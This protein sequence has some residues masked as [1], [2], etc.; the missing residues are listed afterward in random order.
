MGPWS[1]RA[2]L[3]PSPSSSTSLRPSTAADVGSANPSKAGP[4]KKTPRAASLRR[5]GH[6]VVTKS[7]FLQSRR[8]PN[9]FFFLFCR[10]G[11]GDR[12]EWIDQEEDPGRASGL[13]IRIRYMPDQKW[14]RPQQRKSRR[15]KSHVPALPKTFLFLPRSPPPRVCACYLLAPTV[16][17]PS[18]YIWQQDFFP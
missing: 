5:S 10:G 8:F 1:I 4:R 7:P 12:R 2:P 3:S 13:A 15:F 14:W 9:F 16:R 6:L 18:I 11:F 17:D